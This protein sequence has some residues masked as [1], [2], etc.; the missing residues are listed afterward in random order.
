MIKVN[1]EYR[2]IIEKQDHFGS[3]IAKI[4]N[5]LVFIE[6]GLK[7][8]EVVI[9]ITDVKKKYAKASIKKIITPSKERIKPICPYY[10]LCGGCQIMHQDYTNQLKFKEMK[11]RE[12]FSRFPYS[13]N[14]KFYPILHGKDIN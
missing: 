9:K 7:G 11:V 4:D 6:E 3:G 13:E 10:D 5:F 12:L 1:D 14:V 8:D 2:V